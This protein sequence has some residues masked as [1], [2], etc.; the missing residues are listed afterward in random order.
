MPSPMLALCR[1]ATL[2][3]GAASLTARLDGFGSPCSESGKLGKVRNATRPLLRN[4]QR[5]VAGAQPQEHAINN[6]L[7]V[8]ENGAV[9]RQCRVRC[10][11]C[12]EQLH[13]SVEQLL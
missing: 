2:Q 10:W 4:R 6:E 1:A 12:V 8:H 9:C 3:R 5:T 11:L 13:C 7:R